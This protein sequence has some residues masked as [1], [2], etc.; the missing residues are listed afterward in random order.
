MSRGGAKGAEE[1]VSST[2]HAE[3][4]AQHGAWSNDPEITARAKTKSQM[5]NQLSQLGTPFITDWFK[6]THFLCLKILKWGEPKHP[7]ESN[8]KRQSPSTIAWTWAFEHTLSG[9]WANHSDNMLAFYCL[10]H[11]SQTHWTIDQ[12]NG[13]HA[14]VMVCMAEIW[15]NH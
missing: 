6:W 10:L 5:L 15:Q 7:S 3:H 12:S 1:R 13:V 8:L 4:G 14:A 11:N 9:E 2:L